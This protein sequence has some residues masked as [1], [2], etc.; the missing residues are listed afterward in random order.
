MQQERAAG[1]RPGCP[2]ASQGLPGTHRGPAGWPCS[3]QMPLSVPFVKPWLSILSKDSMLSQENQTRVYCSACVCMC[4]CGGEDTAGRA[5][6]APHLYAPARPRWP[7]VCGGGG[8][9]A[10]AMATPCPLN[11]GVCAAVAKQH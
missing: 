9:G 3:A 10:S 1:E 5:D 7:C 8:G 2:Q 6:P 4:V 11:T